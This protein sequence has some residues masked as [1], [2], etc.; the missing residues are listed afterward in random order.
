MRLRGN[1]RTTEQDASFTLPGQAPRPPVRI[2]TR[3][4]RSGCGFFIAACF[5]ASAAAQDTPESLPQ[6]EET[7]EIDR[8]E[9]YLCPEEYH[10]DMEPCRSLPD[11]MNT[12]GAVY[13]QQWPAEILL[14][15]SD[16][17]TL[18]AAQHIDLY[19][20]EPGLDNPALTHNKDDT[21]GDTPALQ[22][23]GEVQATLPVWIDG[24]RIIVGQSPR[25]VVMVPGRTAA[26][27][28]Q[29]RHGPQ[30]AWIPRAD[31]T[32]QRAIVRENEVGQRTVI[33]RDHPVEVVDL[34]AARGGQRINT[35]QTPRR[36][37][38]HAAPVQLV[39]FGM[40]GESVEQVQRQLRKAGFE[41]T[42]DGIFGAETRRAVKRAQG[43]LRAMGFSVSV[44]GIYGTQTHRVIRALEPLRKYAP[45]QP[46][47]NVMVPRTQQRTEHGQ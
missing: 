31:D 17:R 16:G 41:I 10:W 44:D 6:Y 33:L 26:K 32:S 11:L 38:T 3:L 22:N 29:P 45:L 15:L 42:I 46:T 9:I 4:G 13:P 43:E 30:N 40:K 28:R 34:G 24:E 37:N 19:W 7:F 14:T 8:I 47:P 39:K 27:A 5:L 25:T 1:K 35:A 21:P 20:P 23:E 36:Q 2:A 18:R 12:P